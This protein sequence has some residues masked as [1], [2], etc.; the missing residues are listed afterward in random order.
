MQLTLHSESNIT[1]SAPNYDEEDAIAA[2]LA[3]ELN[4]ESAF[5]PRIKG[6]ELERGKYIR[7]RCMDIKKTKYGQRVMLN[8]FLKRDGLED[9][10]HALFLPPSFTEDRKKI[11]LTKMFA[12]VNRCVWMACMK[13][14][15]NAKGH[16]VPLYDFVTRRIE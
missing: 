7:C 6:P 12:L 9:E 11:K 5:P 10:E 13:V 3:D 14:T 8:V 15:Q 16:T 1:M 2:K 4:A